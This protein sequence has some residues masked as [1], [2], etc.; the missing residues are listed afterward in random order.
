[1]PA[2]S[3]YPT[4]LLLALLPTAESATTFINAGSAEANNI[5]VADNWDNGLPTAANPGT[6]AGDATW[7]PADTAGDGSG[8]TGAS[9]NI[10]SGVHIIVTSGTLSRVGNFIPEF[11]D[12]IID[13]Q[14]GSMSNDGPGSRV[15]RLSGTSVLTVGAGSTFTHDPSRGMEFQNDGAGTPSIVIDGGTL[16]GGLGS[17]DT[18]GVSTSDTA[19]AFLT[20]TAN[21]GYAS[22]D[23]LDFSVTNP[24]IDFVS[25][26]TGVL[27]LGNGDAT[28]YED[29]WNSGNLRIDGANSGTFS[30][31][32]I[33]DG[34]QLSL[35]PEPAVTLLGGLG[36]LGLLRRRR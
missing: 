13:L 16:N 31:N 8:S 15:F 3:I 5:F 35:I 12:C 9:A 26:S 18:T 4:L 19:Y 22:F 21:G 30:T 17:G 24:Y 10:A 28:L 7:W 11:T 32:F 23:G 34:T 33:V 1:M 29:L 2:K 25:G 6:I 27:E 36:L 20:F 14:G